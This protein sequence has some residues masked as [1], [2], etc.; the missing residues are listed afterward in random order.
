LFL[1][2]YA[3]LAGFFALEA[4][5]RTRGAASSLD[6]SVDDQGTTDAITTAY[7]ISAVAAPF[8]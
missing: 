1:A 5:S 4:A 6:A 2:G 7:V 3:A 8:L